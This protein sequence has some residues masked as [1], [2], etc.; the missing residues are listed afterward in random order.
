MSLA[1]RVPPVWVMSIPYLTFG[2]MGGFVIVTLPQMLAAVGVPGGHI[3]V[4]VAIITSSGFWAFLLAPLLDVR[5]RRRTYALAFAVLAAA[6]TA[7]TVLDHASKIEAEAVMTI[8]YLSLVMFA[9]ALGGWVASLIRRDQDSSLGAWST[10]ANICGGGLGILLFGYLTQHLAP[11]HAAIIIFTILLAPLLAFFFIPAPPPDK[12]LASES[13]GRFAR[14]VISLLKRRDVLVALALFTL[15][16]AS[17]ALTNV[18]GGIGKDFHVNP[19]LVSIFGGVGSILA[20]IVGCSLVPL[21][22]KKFPLRSLYLGVGFVGAFF[23]LSLLLMPHT[24]WAYGVAFVGENI[25]QAAAFASG[26]AVVFEVVG[27]G[28]PLASTIVALLVS[29]MNFPI[30]Y[31]EIIDG[32]G[33]DWHGVAGAFT[34]DALVS[35]VVCVI[36]WIVLFR[37]LRVQKMLHS[38]E[39]QSVAE[40][41]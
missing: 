36:L 41:K 40:A 32:K 25:F 37:I 14:E 11:A 6:G 20:G 9:A 34:A 39:P 27:P 4:A 29:A 26:L 31:M 24:P 12:M 10:V 18:L 15:P 38:V 1:R 35:G 2:M 23:T 7:L 5:F 30:I 3:A 13:L 33:Y 16:S 17:F 19:G 28:N 22:A 8:G 21:V